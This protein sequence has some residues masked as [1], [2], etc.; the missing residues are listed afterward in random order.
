[1]S[2]KELK[3]HIDRFQRSGLKVLSFVVDYH[4]KLA[5]PMAS[6]IFVLFAA[7]LSLYSKSSK[8]FG[9]AVSLVVTLLYYVATPVC[10]SL[11]VNEVFTPLFAAWLTNGAF[12]LIGIV[13]LIRADRLH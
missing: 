2:R 8:S 12:G 5:M 13:L 3:E 11:A 4:L 10:R 1:M 9:V 7:P 6:F